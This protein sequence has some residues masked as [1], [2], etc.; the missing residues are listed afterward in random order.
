MS[1]TGLN[2][3]IVIGYGCWAA[4]ASPVHLSNA[5]KSST[6][7]SRSGVLDIRDTCTVSG[8]PDLYGLGIRL[9]VYTQ[10]VSSVLAN[11]YH[12]ELI[13]DV[14]DTVNIVSLGF[15]TLLI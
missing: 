11:H 2:V 6:F 3:A 4:V 1:T 12:D 7:S 10:L 8:N 15:Q 13:R 14:R 5:L 9:G